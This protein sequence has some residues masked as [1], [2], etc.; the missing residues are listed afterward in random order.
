MTWREKY[1][2]DPDLAESIIEALRQDLKD[3][4]KQIEMLKFA[5]ERIAEVNGC[6][7]CGGET[8]T[9]IALKALK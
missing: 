4:E 1:R 8:Q 7:E 5:L 9:E 2:R 6:R 3:A